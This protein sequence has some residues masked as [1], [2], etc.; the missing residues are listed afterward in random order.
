MGRRNVNIT[1][2]FYIVLKTSV[3]F[4][5]VQTQIGTFHTYAYMLLLVTVKA[6]KQSL[7]WI[8]ERDILQVNVTW[9]MWPDLIWIVVF[10]DEWTAVTTII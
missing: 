6:V 1:E 10:A 9:S 7:H 8:H 3:G 4:D 2:E 5:N